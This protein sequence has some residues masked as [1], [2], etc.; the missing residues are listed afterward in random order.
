MESTNEEITVVLRF[1]KFMSPIANLNSILVGKEVIKFHSTKLIDKNKYKLINLI[2]E[3]EG[4]IETAGEKFTLLDDS[5]I[6]F[7][8]QAGRKFFLKAVTYH[9]SLDNTEAKLLIK[10]FS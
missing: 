1:G 3:Q 10:N 7:E 6:Y 4:N 8:V 5:I 2:R 9:D